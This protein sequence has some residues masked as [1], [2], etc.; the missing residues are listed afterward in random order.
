MNKLFSRFLNTFFVRG[1]WFVSSGTTFLLVTRALGPAGKGEY[2]TILAVVAIAAVLGDMGLQTALVH[3]WPQTSDK[4]SLAANN[5]LICSVLSIFWSF[6][7]VIITVLLGKHYLPIVNYYYLIFAIINAPLET[8]AQNYT[9][10]FALDNRVL[11]AN[12]AQLIGSLAQSLGVISLYAFG[13]I[14]IFNALLFFT[15]GNIIPLI[16]LIR[17]FKERL[18]D[19]SIVKSVKLIAFSTKFIFGKFSGYLLLRLDILLLAAMLTSSQVGAYSV[20]ETISEMALLS[21]TSIVLVLIH[22]LADKSSSVAYDAILNLLKQSF[23]MAIVMS[24]LIIPL[25][26]ILITE[27]LGN[28]FR[29]SF[30]ALLVLLPGVVALSVV[31]PIA[32]MLVRQNNF[33]MYNFGL[34]LGF[35]LNLG[36]NLIFIP[37]FGILGSAAA[38]SIA[39]IVLA[40]IWT[41]WLLKFKGVTL[42]SLL[43]T[44]GYYK[45][46]FKSLYK[47]TNFEDKASIISET[48]RLKHPIH[49]MNRLR[50][51]FIVKSNRIP[52]SYF[53]II[54][55]VTALECVEKC[56]IIIVGQKKETGRFALRLLAWYGKIDCFFFARKSEAWSF[57]NLSNL[58]QDNL[59]VT[60]LRRPPKSAD[61]KEDKLTNLLN[62]Y[63]LN[64]IIW[65]TD[66]PFNKDLPDINNIF[67]ESG[68]IDSV[69]F[70]NSLLTCLI[71]RRYTFRIALTMIPQSINSTRLIENSVISLHPV[72]LSRNHLFSTR[73]INRLVIRSLH[74]LAIGNLDI[75][76]PNKPELKAE[77]PE[78]KT[79]LTSLIVIYLFNSAINVIKSLNYYLRT[80]RQRP[81]SLYYTSI[82]MGMKPEIPPSLNNWFEFKLP[83]GRFA[84][85]PFP[86]TFDDRNF[87]F[88]EDYH[89]DKNK[90]VISVI[91]ILSD[92]KTTEPQTVLESDDHL[93]FPFVFKDNGRVFML[94]CF[95][96]ANTLELYQSV[97]FPYKWQR[98][99]TLIKNVNA[100]D[101]VI[102]RINGKYWLFFSVLDHLDSKIN[103]MFL[104]FSDSIFGPWHP[105]PLNPVLINSQGARSAG[106][107]FKLDDK[108]VRP[109]QLFEQNYGD[110]I[111]F[112][113]IRNISETSYNEEVLA[114]LQSDDVNAYSIHT[115]NFADKIQ[116]VDFKSTSK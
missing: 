6:L 113:W 111:V 112:N 18:L 35:A 24:L 9:E 95:E 98:C 37:N 82:E 71:K 46:A 16:F 43:P 89:Y 58:D 15:L 94:P 80:S 20:A 23:S 7:A 52:L 115:Y 81:W 40:V 31:Q 30:S 47:T 34:F 5:L 88:F 76:A 54:Q 77:P 83:L 116:V 106:A 19:V 67:F 8:I 4:R 48:K 53:R 39:Y 65:T 107:L 92:M 87:I 56:V 108:W 102:A 61:D 22:K 17:G 75:A 86:I 91:E 51:G 38:S 70:W 62:R 105:H 85:D 44:P 60:D 27:I 66:Q 59:V 32:N 68:G 13:S 72:S 99:A 100:I 12:F 1:L 3:I 26:R 96:H 114:V 90:G 29:G 110:G 55:S 42:L 69:R 78:T 33:R 109:G 45:L 101:P 103:S 28:G 64:T 36:L 14:S 2:V 41:N 104:Y 21:T 73:T 97:E 84:A 25:S 93:S 79:H 11:R 50:V 10:L 63:A 57:T 74:I 49:L